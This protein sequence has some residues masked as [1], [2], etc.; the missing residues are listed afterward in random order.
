MQ[1]LDLDSCRNITDL[2]IIKIAEG[3]PGIQTLDVTCCNRI[4]DTGIINLTEKCSKMQKLT[5]ISCDQITV[6]SITRIA[7]GCPLIEYLYLTDC[8]ENDVHINEQGIRF[9][10]PRNPFWRARRQISF[11]KEGERS[12]SF[13]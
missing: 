7:E 12:V 13:P 11:E 4:T 2:S 10:V 3:C 5:L 6:K 8:R 9:T 1:S